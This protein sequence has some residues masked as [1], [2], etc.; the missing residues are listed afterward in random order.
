MECSGRFLAQVECCSEIDEKYKSSAS[1]CDWQ[2]CSVQC[3]KQST[4]CAAGQA[5]RPEPPVNMSDSE[6][7]AAPHQNMSGEVRN[8][9]LN[10]GYA[11]ALPRISLCAVHVLCLIC[12]AVP[13]LQMTSIHTITALHCSV[14]RV[15]SSHLHPAGFTDPMFALHRRPGVYIAYYH[16]RQ[17]VVETL[18][19]WVLYAESHN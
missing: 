14:L 9:K 19:T 17:V 18:Q 15:Q 4:Y 1:V 2:R 5:V 10:Q 3:H 16:S 8:K 7:Q 11:L 12:M 6:A 13:A